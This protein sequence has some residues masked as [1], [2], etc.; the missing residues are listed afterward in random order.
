MMLQGPYQLKERSDASY[1][2]GEQKGDAGLAFLNQGVTGGL[3]GPEGSAI[4]NQN[5]NQA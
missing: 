3:I 5:I 2:W 4:A 1:K